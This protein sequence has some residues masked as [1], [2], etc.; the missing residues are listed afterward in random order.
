MDSVR[1]CPSVGEN[2]E[3]FLKNDVP[4]AYHYKSHRLILDVVVIA[5]EGKRWENHCD[6]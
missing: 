5:K 1:R 4:E 2:V 3:V 6:V